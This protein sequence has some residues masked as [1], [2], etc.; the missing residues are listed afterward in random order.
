MNTALPCTYQPALQL[1]HEKIEERLHSA[2]EFLEVRDVPYETRARMVMLVLQDWFL[3]KQEFPDWTSR[4]NHA[5]DEIP[6][7]QILGSKEEAQRQG[8]K[9]FSE[10]PDIAVLLWKELILLARPV[11][12]A[13]R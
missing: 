7:V 3:L 10:H 5:S 13:S 1:S 9:C 11:F 8:Y 12:Q 2:I 6:V 4:I